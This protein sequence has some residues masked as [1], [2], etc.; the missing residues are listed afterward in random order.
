M[1]S[2]VAFSVC[3]SDLLLTIQSSKSLV[4]S[5]CINDANGSSV[6]SAVYGT[7]VMCCGLALGSDFLSVHNLLFSVLT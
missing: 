7:F 2:D 6:N 5:F 4:C 1:T 3:S